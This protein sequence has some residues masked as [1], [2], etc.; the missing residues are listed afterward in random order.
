MMVNWFEN[1][2]TCVVLCGGG[3]SR[4]LPLSLLK[5]KSMIEVNEKPILQH[6]IDYWKSY[7]N[8]F[9]FIVKYKK[10]DI[11]NFV[12]TLPIEAE[13]VEP[14]EIKGLAD[15][16]SYV[17]DLVGERFFV[18]LGDCLCKGN[19]NFPDGIEQGIAVCE[20]D[21][22][23]E[24]ARSYSVELGENTVIR[25]VVEKP[26]II[27]NKMCGMGF[28]FFKRTIFEYIN[29]AKGKTDDLTT[30]VQHMIDNGEKVHAIR[31]N[32][33]YLNITF[34]NDLERAEEILKN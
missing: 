1:K 7:T 19:F 23:E 8:K 4:L 31:F 3:G 10:E 11:I 30:I 33:R 34:P 14:N 22:D 6:I 5:Q 28:Y 24:I 2:P 18:V 15:A 13:F 16:L 17:K 12:K 29:K 25:K 9:V 20:T 32:G 26:Q 27:P 21:K